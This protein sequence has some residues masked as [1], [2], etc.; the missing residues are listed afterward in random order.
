MHRTASAVELVQQRS[1]PMPSTRAPFESAV[2]A[3]SWIDRFA[4]AE[5]EE[6]DSNRPSQA[7]HQRR[8]P[9]DEVVE[10]DNEVL[11][12]SGHPMVFSAGQVVGQETSETIR[13]R[14]EAELESLG[15][16]ENTLL[17][18]ASGSLRDWEEAEEGTEG[19]VPNFLDEAIRALGESRCF[20][21]GVGTL[22][23]C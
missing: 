9:F 14:L 10:Y 6:T 3:R 12:M 5:P 13:K 17:S 7:S 23:S 11:D 18:G 16:S 2:L 19:S 15:L 1:P 20:Q 4:V 22:R 21:L 8:D